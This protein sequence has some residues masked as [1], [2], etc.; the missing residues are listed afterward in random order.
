MT[1]EGS[2]AGD[3]EAMVVTNGSGVRGVGNHLNTSR[4]RK[5]LIQTD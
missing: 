3:D 2:E 5:Q 1:V 4:G